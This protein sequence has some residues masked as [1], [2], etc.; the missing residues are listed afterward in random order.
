LD[1]AQQRYN[2]GLGS[3]VEFTQAE[4]GKTEADIAD[5]EPLTN[6]A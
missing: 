3:T 6:I 4:L 5:T 2:L 1:L